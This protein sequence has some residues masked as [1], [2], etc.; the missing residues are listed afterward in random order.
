[1]VAHKRRTAG[2]KRSRPLVGGDVRRVGVEDLVIGIEDLD[3]VPVL[4]EK[5][6]VRLVAEV[7]DLLIRAVPDE[8]G[9]TPG[10]FVGDE[11]DGALNGAEISRPSPE[12]TIRAES[13]R[14]GLFLVENVQPLFPLKPVKRPSVKVSTPG[15]IWT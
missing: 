9:D 11:I 6:D 3:L 10:M 13:A 4:A 1:M 5:R 8:D 12:T 15:S 14:G 7:D 2:R